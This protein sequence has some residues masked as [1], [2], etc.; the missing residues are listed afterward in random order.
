MIL[1]FSSIH[2]EPT[3][4]I[5]KILKDLLPLGKELEISYNIEDLSERLRRPRGSLCIAVL[6]FDAP[7]DLSALLSLEDPFKDID[8]ILILPD[9]KSD[10]VIKGYKL[11]PRY[12]GYKKD[13]LSELI[14]VLAKMIK[15]HQNYEPE[16]C[17]EAQDID[18]R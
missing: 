17:N 9:A 5:R 3:G 1:L 13:D 12:V 2:D 15:K 18:Y 7:D 6:L 4:R 16:A 14:L 10:T 8:I 11:Y